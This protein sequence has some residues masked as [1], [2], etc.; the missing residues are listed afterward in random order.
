MFQ[1]ILSLFTGIPNIILNRKS[2]FRND[3]PL[4]S[5]INDIKVSICH[6]AKAHA[7]VSEWD[8]PWPKSRWAWCISS[9]IS[10]SNYHQIVNHSSSIQTAFW[11]LHRVMCSSISRRETNRRISIDFFFKK[12]ER[13]ILF[14]VLHC[15]YSSA[16]PMSECG[17]ACSSWPI[18]NSL[19]SSTCRGKVIIIISTCLIIRE[20][21]WFVITIVWH[22][23]LRHRPGIAQMIN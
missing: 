15:D 8:S 23:P 14:H 1:L 17:S 18:H 3:L 19:L 12:E 7:F 20:L 16:I 10:K 5:K 11:E 9:R 22:T 6:S 2:L 4:M 13:T 21:T